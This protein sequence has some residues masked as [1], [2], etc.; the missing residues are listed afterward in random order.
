VK[1]FHFGEFD[2]ISNVNFSKV[3]ESNFP[4]ILWWTHPLVPCNLEKKFF[5]DRQK[6]VLPNF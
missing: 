4:E 2:Q 5:E 6:P 1:N 3:A